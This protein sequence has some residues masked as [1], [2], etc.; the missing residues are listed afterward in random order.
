M[1]ISRLTTL[2][3]MVVVLL[4]GVVMAGGWQYSGVGARAKAMGGAYRGLSNDGSGAY[5]NPG[6]LAFLTTNY[7]NVTAEFS[8]PRPEVTP[9]FNSNAYEF[10]YLNGQTRYPVKDNVYLMGNSALFF[11]HKS[12]EKLTF[13]AAVYQ[14]YDH[15]AV[16]NLFQIAPTYNSRTQVPEDNHR[17]NVDVVTF[18]PTLSYKFSEKFGLGIGLQINRGDLWVDQVHFV[19]NPYGYPLNIRPYDKF[20]AMTSIDGFGYGLGANIGFQY[21][22]SEKVTVGANYITSSKIKIDGDA[23]ERIYFPYNQGIAN[24]YN[25]PQANSNPLQSEIRYTYFNGLEWVVKGQF[26]VDMKLPSEFGAGVA[27]QANERTIVS[28][29]FTYTM[30]SQFDDLAVTISERD[31]LKSNNPNAYDTWR[32]L[33]TGPHYTFEW[34]DAI[35]ISAGL[36]RVINDRWVARFGYM[37]DGSPIPDE[38]FNALFIDTGNKH[39]F[40]VGASFVLNDRITF[41]GALEAVFAG[42][43]EIGEAVDTNGDGSW[44]NFGGEWKTKNFNSTWALNYRF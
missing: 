12:M 27:I 20:P 13:G 5:Y 4:S 8:G 33:L 24:L 42:S 3:L 28:A 26:D 25:D 1:R 43:R 18:Q 2:S 15:N 14:M 19:D 23:V 44:D 40:N 29:D 9:N 11:K 21:K 17:S 31:Y 41:D 22:A 34:D 6:G 36:E 35:R 16:M 32:S 39:H 37:F 30:W 10:G 38:T 7:F